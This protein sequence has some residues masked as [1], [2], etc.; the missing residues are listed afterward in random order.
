MA[1]GTFRDAVLAVGK[2]FHVTVKT[3]DFRLMF[4]SV[5]S[6]PLRLLGM[7]FYAVCRL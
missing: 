3:G 2:V 4:S 6:D 1:A 7:A 5:A